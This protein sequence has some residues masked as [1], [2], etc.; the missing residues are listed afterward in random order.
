MKAFF[1]PVLLACVLCRPVAAA[2]DSAPETSAAPVDASGK[3]DT[4]PAKPAIRKGMTAAEIEKIIG[5]PS[6]IKPIEVGETKG[7][8][9]IYRRVAKRTMTQTAAALSMVPAYGGLG[10]QGDAIVN[11]PEPEQRLESITI[12]QMT[13]L[14]MVEGKLVASK[15]WF[16]KERRFE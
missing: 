8:S 16:E 7:E 9:W 1:V 3:Q 4:K 5:K 12:Y 6:Q 14:L 15:Q 13:A 10:L 11:V 2:D